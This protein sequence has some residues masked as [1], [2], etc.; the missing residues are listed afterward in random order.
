MNLE[1]LLIL[2]EGK[3]NKPYKDTV[4]KTTIGIGR[5]LDDKGLS[6]SE[7]L[8]L[9]RNDLQQHSKEVEQAFPWVSGLDTARRAVLIDMCFNMGIGGLS[10]FNR[11]LELI[12]NGE[13]EKAAVAMLQS[14]WATQVGNRAKRLSEMM[15]TGSWPKLA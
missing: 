12:R 13:Y 1:Q 7:V 9:F 5:N 15:R 3:R 14:K 11:T 2:H 4:G 6:D 10:Q 8:Y